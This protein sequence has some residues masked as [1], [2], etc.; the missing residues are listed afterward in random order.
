MEKYLIRCSSSHADWLMWEIKRK[1]EYWNYPPKINRHDRTIVFFESN[2]VYLA[3]DDKHMVGR[4]DYI[5]ITEDA[6]FYAINV[7][8]ENIPMDI[9]GRL[10]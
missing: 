10:W 6:I 8:N 3:T 7:I 2:I 1:T 9:S 5:Q 4:R